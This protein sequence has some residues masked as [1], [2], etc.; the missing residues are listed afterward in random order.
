MAYLDQSQMSKLHSY[1]C[2]ELGAPLFA[3]EYLIK[4]VL[5]LEY[6]PMKPS[7]YNDR[8]ETI[9]WLYLSICVIEHWFRNHWMENMKCKQT[10][11]QLTMVDVAINWT[12]GKD[13]PN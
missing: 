12:M 9:P 11:E 7:V 3:T 2:Y 1:L 10:I 4:Q 5:N 8:C 6:V 13:I